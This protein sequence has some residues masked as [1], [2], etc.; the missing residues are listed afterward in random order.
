[1]H[2]S[3]YKEADIMG[4]LNSNSVCGV[5]HT[6]MYT[7]IWSSFR[8]GFQAGEPKEKKGKISRNQL[9]WKVECE[10]KILL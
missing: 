4:I 8:T 6:I 9:Q 2:Y 5:K 1:M 3:A 10:E 7:F